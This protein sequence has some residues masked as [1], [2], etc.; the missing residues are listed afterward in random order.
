MIRNSKKKMV[1]TFNLQDF[2]I[3][4][5][6]ELIRLTFEHEK[7]KFELLAYGPK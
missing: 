4:I 6:T 7:L 2:D 5:F 3:N 1:K